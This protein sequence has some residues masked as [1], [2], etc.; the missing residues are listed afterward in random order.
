MI[1]AKN[2]TTKCGVEQAVLSS[3]AS[4]RA[5]L[6]A[7]SME[8]RH[9]IFQ[10]LLL[11][12][13]A[14]AVAF[15]VS[16]G[17][18][19]SQRT[20]AI[21]EG[22]CA[23]QVVAANCVED[24]FSSSIS[25]RIISFAAAEGVGVGGN[26]G[27]AEGGDKGSR[28]SRGV[29]LSGSTSSL[30]SEPL[31]GPRLAS[32]LAVLCPALG[33]AFAMLWWYSLSAIGIDPSSRA[34]GFISL[35]AADD[36]NSVADTA[37]FASFGGRRSY[38]GFGG[39]EEGYGVGGMGVGMGV[40]GYLPPPPAPLSNDTLELISN[41][42]ALVSSGAM[43]F[44][45][46]EYSYMSRFMAGFAL[47]LFAFLGL[48][49]GG[50]RGVGDALAY[51]SS[52]TSSSNQSPE[53]ANGSPTPW[54]SAALSVVAFLIGALTS[55]VAGWLGL[56]VA[57]YANGRT[58][59]MAADGDGID[60][61]RGFSGAFRTALRGGAA[62]GF[63]LTSMCLF[64]LFFT[65]RL[66]CL[67]FGDDHGRIAEAHECV[68]AFGLGSSAVA[69]F[70]RVGGGI[71]TKAADVGADLVG[72][73]EKNIPEDDPRNPGVIADCIGDN[74][75]DV[76]GMGTD[77]FGSL[78]EA[79]C[80]ALLIAAASPDLARSHTAMLYPLLV[81][82]CGL[83]AGMAAAV[84]GATGRGVRCAEYVEPALKRQLLFATLIATVLIVPLTF[85]SLPAAPFAVLGVATTRSRA[86]V[87][88]L[89]G[90]WAGLFIGR[91]AEHF[92][93]SA[94]RPVREVAES[95]ETG[96]A[97]TIIYG[98]AL[99]HRSVVGP[100]LALGA[101]VYVSYRACGLYGYAL[102]ALGMLATMATALAIHAF[103]PIADNAGGFAEMAA[104]GDE[105][106]EVT[107]AL[108]AAGNTTAA[109][110]KGY[111]IGSAALVGLA[112]YGAFVSRAG[113]ASVDVLDERVLAGL[114][115][116]AMLP[117]VFTA[118]TIKSV[119]IAAMEIVRE[120][121]RQFADPR[122]AA[123]EQAPDY[124]SC[125]AIATDAALRQ[126]AAPA[127]LVLLTPLAVGVA[128]GAHAL[129]GLLPGALV[130]GVQLAISS[131]NTGG[132][133][134]NA[135]K[136][137]EQGGLGRERRKGK[138]SPQHAAAVI[139]DTVGDPLK[140]TS[141]PALNILV[142]LMAIISVVFAPVFTSQVGGILL[143]AIGDNDF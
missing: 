143:R 32:A 94:Y 42:T 64:S 75:G 13:I 23:G 20:S 108:D 113:I 34:A 55:A 26:R 129:A 126:M 90:L 51:S 33:F 72:K 70:G 135:K 4:H 29:P 71:F 136:Y 19:T 140:D 125:V 1:A 121:R 139:G 92:T 15:A 86:A 63:G 111:A 46:A 52:S 101:T 89:S 18:L 58:A 54:L 8:R 43:A 142:K 120:I 48:S 124:A 131:A 41:I 141:G 14:C 49:N 79:T 110:G 37:G 84:L 109:I 45:K 99:G 106:R 27:V 3:V 38:G 67:C 56:R 57:V 73:V 12:L 81:S 10:C 123:G 59:V 115:A 102:A 11:P 36:S 66:V 21:A 85:A 39:P 76:A 133:W 7:S 68:A 22:D 91:S 116:G 47:L 97:T 78:S 17:P 105:V 137:I 53:D 87:C 69:C 65:A 25:L 95:C 118:M 74:V 30:A 24:L 88:V 5:L 62:M 82:G 98:L 114:L 122:I 96:P 93:S 44:L 134:D 6:P 112:L 100:V 9:S 128:F 50:G 80:A 127:L 35:N 119:G 60:I 16:A 104:L 31:L 40:G 61:A 77:L 117:F 107:D 132:A 103:G 138:G 2:K 130:T 28:K 83:V